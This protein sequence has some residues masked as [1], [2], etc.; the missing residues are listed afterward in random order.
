MAQPKKKELQLSPVGHAMIG[1]T[2]GTPILQCDLLEEIQNLHKED[3]W[4]QG[5]GPSSKTLVKH[6]DLRIVLLAMK[7]KMC[8]HE[9]RRRQDLGA[10]SRRTHSPQAAGSHGGATHGAVACTRSMRSVTMSKR[11]KIVLSC[12]PCRGMA[13]NPKQRDRFTEV[14]APFRI[15]GEDWTRIGSGGQGEILNGMVVRSVLL[16]LA[17]DGLAAKG[18]SPLRKIKI[19]MP[20]VL[21][22]AFHAHLERISG[23]SAGAPH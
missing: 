6:P 16:S 17:D 7:K 2:L 10:D 23:D 18:Y 22:W 20:I 3:A 13:K 15:S 8:M 9:H 21:T 5:T 12:S 14:S 4:L 11:R 1:D 19:K